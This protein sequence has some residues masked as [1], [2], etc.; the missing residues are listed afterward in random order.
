MSVPNELTF[1]VVGEDVAIV[2]FLVQTGRAAVKATAIGSIDLVDTVAE[3]C[4]EA[5]LVDL[6]SEPMAV[7][8]QVERLPAPRPVLLV[9]GPDEKHVMLRA[10]RLGAREYVSPD[11]E[12]KDQLVHAIE[13]VLKERRSHTP[14]Q[15]DAPL[16]AVMGSKGGV[17]TTFASCQI[18]ASLAR[19]GG[20][21]AVLDGH[22]RLGD[23]A[24]YYDIEPRYTM[25]D[26]TSEA[27]R[28]DSAYLENVLASH[29][30]GVDILAAPER[31][32]QADAISVAHLDRALGLLRSRSDWVVAD[33]PRNF[34]DHSV[35]LIDRASTLVLVTTPDVPAL[36]HT[37]LHLDLLQRL[38][39]PPERVRVVLN[40]FERKAPIQPDELAEFLGRPFAAQIVNDFSN[41]SLC[42]NE[43]KTAW[44]INSRSAVTASLEHLAVE[45]HD[46]CGRPRPTEPRSARTGL[47]G[48]LRRKN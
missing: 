16:I 29:R 6:G 48:R 33:T 20:T 27:E 39:L 17:G 5:I 43:G 26:L 7:L 45:I 9:L 28:V 23:V 13:R 21:V 11:A 34:T 14:E 15:G 18:A 32:E 8:D 22:L 38:G 44:E 42:I 30:C 40:R 36:N 35:H 41:A 19:G 24:L 46:W 25:A 1:V 4:P 37:R 10:M 2:D 47:L 12:G 31:P 3:A